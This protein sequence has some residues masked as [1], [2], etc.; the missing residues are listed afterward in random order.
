MTPAAILSLRC[1]A[2]LHTGYFDLILTSP[3][4]FPSQRSSLCYARPAARHRFRAP[5]ARVRHRITRICPN[6]K[7]THSWAPETWTA[8]TPLKPVKPLPHCMSGACPVLS[9]HACLDESTC[10]TARPPAA[11]R[12]FWRKRL[13]SGGLQFPMCWLV[14]TLHPVGSSYARYL[15]RLLYFIHK[16]TL[17]IAASYPFSNPN[18]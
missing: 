7:S 16:G 10:P 4:S 3:L 13:A 6:N 1:I 2:G 17:H 5:R 9:C 18:V 15:P 12:L 14:G 8:V 11:P